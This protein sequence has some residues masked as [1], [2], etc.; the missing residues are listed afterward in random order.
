VTLMYLPS[1]SLII[2]EVDIY[3]FRKNVVEAFN[4]FEIKRASPALK[5]RVRK[6]FLE[7]TLKNDDAFRLSSWGVGRP[8]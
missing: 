1:E 7:T 4:F 5:Q 8:A 6:Q 2:A 3:Y